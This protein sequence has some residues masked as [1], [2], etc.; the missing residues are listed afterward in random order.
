MLALFSNFMNG[1]AFTPHCPRCLQSSENVTACGT[2]IRHFCSWKHGT[3]TRLEAPAHPLPH[4]YTQNYAIRPPVTTVPAHTHT[5]SHARTHVHAHAPGWTWHP[6]KSA[7][8]PNRSFWDLDAYPALIWTLPKTPDFLQPSPAL[9]NLL[10]ITHIWH[11]LLF[12]L[13]FWWQ[14]KAFYL[15]SALAGTV[16]LICG[17]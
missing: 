6:N 14:K 2:A 12:Y 9:E 8:T 5:H 7:T 4:R 16:I 10:S 15:Q 13:S 1:W 17:S 11:S 3:E